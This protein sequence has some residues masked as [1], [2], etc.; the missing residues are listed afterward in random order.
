MESRI[1]GFFAKIFSCLGVWFD[2]SFFGKLF[3]RISFRLGKLFANSFIG[4]LFCIPL[5]E[6]KAFTESVFWKI[7]TLPILLL[8]KIAACISDSWVNV[9]RK[10]VLL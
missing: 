6:K 4:R 8:K 3:N 9:Y 2:A 7:I 5:C 1:Y 10:S